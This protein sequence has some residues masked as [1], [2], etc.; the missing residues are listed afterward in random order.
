[1][2][3]TRLPSIE[4]DEPNMSRKNARPLSEG[5]ATGSSSLIA[6]TTIAPRVPSKKR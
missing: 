4:T 2:S 6:S 3:D 5:A 1:M